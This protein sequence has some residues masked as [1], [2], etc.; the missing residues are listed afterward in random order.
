ML[1]HVPTQLHVVLPCVTFHM[2]GLI[3]G[4]TGFTTGAKRL[5][6]P[7]Q[8]LSQLLLSPPA[9]SISSPT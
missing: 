9:T 2:C 6:V 5:V 7:T 4:V 3:L 8:E 1:T